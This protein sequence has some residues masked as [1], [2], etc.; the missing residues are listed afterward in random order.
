MLD[1]VIR[2]ML[3]AQPVPSVSAGKIRL[4]SSATPS[5]MP[6]DGSHPSV[7]EN[8]MT[9][10]SP[11]Q[12]FGIATPISPNTV[13]TLSIQVYCFFADKIPI[14]TPISIATRIPA[15]DKINVLGK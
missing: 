3:A 1:R 14:G 5:P 8:S 13:V 10:S 11:N 9:S 12:K 15:R 2:I 4:G 6:E 7:T